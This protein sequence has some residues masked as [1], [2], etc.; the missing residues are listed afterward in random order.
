VAQRRLTPE[1][2]VAL[3]RRHLDDGV[4]LTRLSQDSCIPVRTSAAGSSPTVTAR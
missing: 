4:P 2:K 3:L 1:E